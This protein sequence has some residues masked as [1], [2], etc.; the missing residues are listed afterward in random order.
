MP[1]IPI[2]VGD[3]PIARMIRFDLS[4]ID[5]EIVHLLKTAQYYTCTCYGH[6]IERHAYVSGY[7]N[8][9]ANYTSRRS[10][11]IRRYQVVHYR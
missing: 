11:S 10:Y 3:P 5:G 1:F 9:K 6:S 4:A 8:S 7:E 2:E